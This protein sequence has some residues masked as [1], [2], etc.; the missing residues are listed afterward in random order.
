MMAGAASPRR[1]A[2]AVANRRDEPRARSACESGSVIG[3]STDFKHSLCL[4]CPCNWLSPPSG[5]AILRQEKRMPFPRSW[6]WG[7][8]L[9]RDMFL[10]PPTWGAAV[11]VDGK[12]GTR[13]APSADLGPTR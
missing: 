12:P 11:F 1:M 10:S 3:D 8:A 4:Q 7:V 9:A 6:R 5:E 13:D 2:I